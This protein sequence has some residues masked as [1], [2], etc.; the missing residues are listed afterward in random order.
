WIGLLRD[1][2]TGRWRI[3]LLIVLGTAP[4]AIAGLALQS[5]VDRELRGST[6][7]VAGLLVG[8][9]VIWLAERFRDAGPRSLDNG[10][11]LGRAG[12][13]QMTL[14]DALGVGFAQAVALL[15]GISRS[16]ITISAGLFRGL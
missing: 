13:H 8:S 15:P 11:P 4:G 14:G 5:L 2:V 6:P 1:V 16:G 7:I 10:A 3:P 12:L 9:L